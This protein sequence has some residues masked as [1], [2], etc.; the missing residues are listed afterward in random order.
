MTAT[1][2]IAAALACALLL[3]AQ[4]DGVPSGLGRWVDFQAGTVSAR[5]RTIENSRGVRTTN[6]VQYSGL[7]SGRFKIDRGAQL[8]LNTIY[9]TGNN[10]IGSWNN[11]SVGTGDFAGR[12][13]VKQLYAAWRPASGVELSYGGMGFAR[14]VSTEITTYD[15]DGY[16]VGERVSLRRPKD[17][18]FD[19]LTATN[20][21]LGDLAEPSIFD[22]LDHLAGERNYHQ[23]LASKTVGRI[24]ASLDYSH[25]A[26]APY[27]RL[28]IMGRTPELRVVDSVRLEH[29]SRFE[30]DPA[31]GF[32]LHLEKAISSRLTAT[33]GYADIDPLY[34]PI[35]AD[36]FAIGKRFYGSAA[37]RLTADLTAHLFMTR[38]VDNDFAVPIGERID[39]ALVYNVLGALRRAQVFR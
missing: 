29:Y 17:L 21:Y 37:M 5:Y 24:S 16:M 25:L 2:I 8:T 35:N 34:R 12:W 33:A 23:L 32:N 36:R 4:G 22:R 13:Y 31:S 20:G 14:G 6:Q 19:E 28:A 39:V 15:N 18:F 1:L 27:V 10:F 26:G 3:P 7:L 11:T 9:A 30:D 38:S